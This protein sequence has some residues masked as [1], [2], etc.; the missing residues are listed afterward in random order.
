FEAGSDLPRLVDEGQHLPR[1]ILPDQ[2][3]HRHSRRAAAACG[4]PPVFSPPKICVSV[5]SGTLSVSDVSPPITN[6]SWDAGAQPIARAS[7]PVNPFT[8]GTSKGRA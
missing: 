4:K 3:G 1:L 8:G 2:V 6:A 5:L 7:K